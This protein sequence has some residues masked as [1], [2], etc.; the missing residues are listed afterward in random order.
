MSD[1]TRDQWADVAQYVVLILFWLGLIVLAVRRRKTRWGAVTRAVTVVLLIQSGREGVGLIRAIN[2]DATLDII[3]RTL[4]TAMVASVLA[5]M[6]LVR[7]D[8]PPQP[9][10]VTLR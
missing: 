6:L 3:R 7:R 2:E 10:I 9:P 8:K 1:L 5:T 4:R